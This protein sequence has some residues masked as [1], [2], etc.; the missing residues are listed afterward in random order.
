[1]ND[2]ILS[3]RRAL[4]IVGVGVLVGVALTFTGLRPSGR[5]RPGARPA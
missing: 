4:V 1:M 3:T 2:R 5:S